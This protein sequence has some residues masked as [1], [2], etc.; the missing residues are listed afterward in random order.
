MN[1][2][3]PETD[4]ANAETGSD[5]I[6]SLKA[7]PERTEVPSNQEDAEEREP[8]FEWKSLR[9]LN[10]AIQQSR[11]PLV[12]ELIVRNHGEE[13]LSGLSC[14]IAVEPASFASEKSVF[15]TFAAAERPPFCSCPPTTGTGCP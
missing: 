10:L 5:V 11:F 3:S 14:T 12:P 13:P 2:S 15:S 6:I 9:F 8:D 4:S 7:Q 1:D